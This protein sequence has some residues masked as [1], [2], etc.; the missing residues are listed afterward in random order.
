VRDPADE[1]AQARQPLGL[2]QPRLVPFLLCLEG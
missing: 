2:R 1:R